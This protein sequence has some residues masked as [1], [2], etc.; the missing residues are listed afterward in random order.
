M[1][2]TDYSLGAVTWQIINGILLVLIIFLI[3][4]YLIKSVRN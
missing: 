1:E 3:I 4:R 2:L